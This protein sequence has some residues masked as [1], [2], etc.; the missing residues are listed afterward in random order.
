MHAIRWF[1]FLLFLAALAGCEPAVVQ[2]PAG[3][4]TNPVATGGGNTKPPAAANTPAPERFTSVEAA[5]EALTTA[6][7]EQD[8]ARLRSSLAYLTEQGSAAVPPLTR[9]VKDDSADLAARLS[10]CRALA[11]I[12]PPGLDA[13]LGCLNAKEAILRL[14]A[15]EVLGG[16]EPVEAR[17]IDA[18]IGLLNDDDVRMRAKAIRSLG[19]IGTAAERA[20]PKLLA[21]L[22]SPG[23]EGV[24]AEASDAL[25]KVDPRRKFDTPE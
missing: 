4:R 1:A 11:Q 8:D 2:Q 10:A 25:R 6:S 21:I 22:N 15:A 17:S 3:N 9:L 7:R 24:R 23:D 5:I 16:M 14:R 20:T 12:G 13:V 18:L 19:R